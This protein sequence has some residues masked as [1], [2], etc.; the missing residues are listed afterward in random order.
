V[1]L[2]CN[3]AGVYRGGGMDSVTYEDWDWVMG[4]NVGGVINGVQTW[5]RR[6]KAHGQGGHI[7]NTASMSGMITSPGMGIYNTSK[8]AVVGLSEALREDL[9]ESGIGVSVLCPGM[10]R[11]R[12]LESERTRPDALAPEDE[13]AEAAAQAHSEVMHMAMNA[14]IPAEEV[15]QMVVNGVRQNLMYLFPHPELKASTEARVQAILDAFG[16]ADPARVRAQEEFLAS[17]VQ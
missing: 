4:V 12:I 10:V 1:H 6:I 14:G 13:E 9:A 17:L 3:N 15:A 5:I 2:V 8:F 16:E 11:T 7:V